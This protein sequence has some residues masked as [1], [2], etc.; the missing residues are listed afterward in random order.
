MALATYSSENDIEQLSSYQLDLVNKIT[1]VLTPIE[2]VTK[3]I[4]ANAA[5]VS[6]I[7]P[8]IR[9]LEKS[10]ENTMLTVV[11]I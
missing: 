11:F 2:E 6:A 3:S 7:I 10:L 1:S 4:P 8:F 5:S 9:M